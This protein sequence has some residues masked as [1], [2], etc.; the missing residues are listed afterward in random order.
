MITK[1]A[2]AGHSYVHYQCLL[3]VMSINI[4][5]IN[6]VVGPCDHHD[7]GNMATHLCCV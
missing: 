2:P 5:I 1:N 6:A 4:I 7:V 3:I